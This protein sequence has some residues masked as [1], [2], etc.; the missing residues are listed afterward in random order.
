M[1]ERHWVEINTRI[2]YPIKA[3]LNKMVE[4]EVID[5]RN[6]TDKFCVSFITVRVVQAG[7]QELL[8]AW[9]YHHIPGW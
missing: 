2:N 1:A 4:E 5:M 6:E 7:V 3:Y 9:N 8:P